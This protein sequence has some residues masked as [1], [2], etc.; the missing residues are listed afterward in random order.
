MYLDEFL[1][2]FQ[3]LFSIFNNDLTH[4]CGHRFMHSFLDT[5]NLTCICGFVIE[6]ICRYSITLAL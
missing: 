3:N 2:Y 5:F 4:L 1:K 6:S